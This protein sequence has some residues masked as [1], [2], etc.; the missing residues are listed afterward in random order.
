VVFDR[1]VL[2][3][4][5]FEAQ[6]R[7][8]LDSLLFCVTRA[9]MTPKL[10]TD[11]ADAGES[12]L[13][14][15]CGLM[16]ESRFSVHDLSRC[17]ATK[18]GEISRL[19]MPFELGI[20]YGYRNCG[21]PGLATKRF[22]VM[23]EK[24]HR[25][26]QALSDINGWDPTAH[27]GNAEKALKELRNWLNQEAGTSLPGGDI[28]FGESLIFAERKLGQPDHARADV[29]TYSPF[30]LTRAMLRWNDLGRPENP[31]TR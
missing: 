19:N 4:C 11:R 22:L 27:E 10:A 23:D 15:I 31:M 16:K 28:L 3:N 8:V 7:P 17:Q 12:R 18:K 20:D 21:N 26:R 9:G 25:L 30:E 6:Y 1:N 5:P 24:P 29:D 13:E 2:I 14:K